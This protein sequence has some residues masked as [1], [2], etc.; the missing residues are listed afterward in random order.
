MERARATKA[1]SSNVKPG[2]WDLFSAVISNPF[3]PEHLPFVFSGSGILLVLLLGMSG[4]LS[5]MNVPK[6]AKIA[7]VNQPFTD[8]QK[9][10]APVVTN[11]TPL[12]RSDSKTSKPQMNFL[13][14]KIELLEN[15]IAR[16]TDDLEAV[17]TNDQTLSNRLSSIETSFNMM[18]ASIN[19]KVTHLPAQAKPG[20]KGR[21][22]PLPP[23]SSLPPKEANTPKIGPQKLNDNTPEFSR[24]LFAAYLGANSDRANLQKYREELR[25]KY[26]KLLKNLDIYIAQPEKGEKKFRLIVGPLTNLAV[27][28]KICVELKTDGKFC[29]QDIFPKTLLTEINSQ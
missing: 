16:L 18:T 13:E 7:Q 24:T 25:V 20:E 27:A 9:A 2:V 4:V 15:K 10:A 3:A 26:A 28:T 23:L 6:P 5:K 8:A 19:G 17:R 1:V 12:L 22:R 21:T 11:S 29:H 14:A